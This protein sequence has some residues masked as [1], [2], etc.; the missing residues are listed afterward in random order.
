ML[1]IISTLVYGNKVQP[2]TRRSEKKSFVN[3]EN[4]FFRS[5]TGSGNSFEVANLK[6]VA[7]ELIE[8]RFNCSTSLKLASLAFKNL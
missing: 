7:A 5:A 6:F 2:V 3:G 1:K 4:V 8:L